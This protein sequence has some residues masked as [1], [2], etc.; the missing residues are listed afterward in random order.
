MRKRIVAWVEDD[1][2][3][4]TRVWVAMAALKEDIHLH[5]VPSGYELLEMLRDGEP[6][7]CPEIAFMSLLTSEPG[8]VE[9]IRWMKSDLVL[10]RTPVIGYA[11]ESRRDLFLPAYASGVNACM[12]CPSAHPNLE[13]VLLG[14][15][16]F[17]LGTARLPSG[18]APSE[19]AEPAHAA[20]AAG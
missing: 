4:Q 2:V 10:R 14:S 20:V 18:G 11:P 9:L 19:F 5:M 15:L 7:A 1:P 6:G 12:L 3:E 13:S 17:W 8:A 16:R